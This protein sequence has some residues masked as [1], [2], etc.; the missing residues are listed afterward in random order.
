MNARGETVQELLGFNEQ[1]AVNLRF[2]IRVSE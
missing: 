2:E 1:M